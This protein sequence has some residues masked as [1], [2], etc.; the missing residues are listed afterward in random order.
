MYILFYLEDS[1]DILSSLVEP[2]KPLLLEGS[3]DEIL[4]VDERLTY[5]VFNH[6]DVYASP[7]IVG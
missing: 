4:G 2:P 7:F 6:D 3:D 5:D 1:H